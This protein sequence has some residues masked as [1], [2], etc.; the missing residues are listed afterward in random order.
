MHDIE[1]YNSYNP[2]NIDLVLC[3]SNNIAYILKNIILKCLTQPFLFFSLAAL[4]RFKRELLL[5]VIKDVLERLYMEGSVNKKIVRNI[6]Y[7]LISGSL[8]T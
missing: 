5:Y 6:S 4:S 8:L 3:S 2:C 7:C 1:N